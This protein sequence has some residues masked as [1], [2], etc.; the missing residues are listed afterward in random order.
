MHAKASTQNSLADTENE[1]ARKRVEIGLSPERPTANASP[2]RPPDQPVSLNQRRWLAALFG[3]AALAV[4]LLIWAKF[5][6]SPTAWSEISRSGDLS[7]QPSASNGL[8]DESL[9]LDEDA[10]E[11]PWDMGALEEGTY[12]MRIEPGQAAWST[13]DT[14]APVPHRVVA[15]IVVSAKTPEGYGGLIGRHQNDKNFY[16]FWVNGKGQFQILLQSEGQLYTLRDWTDSETVNLAGT[17]NKLAIEDNGS[18]LKFFNNDVFLIEVGNLIFPV[19]D[20]GVIGGAAGEIVAE[21]EF[22]RFELIRTQ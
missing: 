8:T 12:R 9:V 13:L 22:D 17:L 1:R 18:T 4:L 10:G 11:G 20:V 16:F 5:I 7:E 21:V 6:G 2:L 15:D 14:L 19:A 3:L